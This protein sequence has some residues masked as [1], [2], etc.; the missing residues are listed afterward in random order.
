M[1]NSRPASFAS[2]FSGTTPMAKITRSEATVS[3]VA[4][5][6]SPLFL[7]EVLISFAVSENP[8]TSAPSFKVMP[9][10]RMRLCKSDAMSGS[11]ECI[12]WLGRWSKVTFTPR[13]TRF[14][15]ISRPMN[16]PPTTVARKGFDWA[17]AWL[18]RSACTFSRYSAIPKVSSTVRRV[19][20]REELMPGRFG[21]TGWAPGDKISLS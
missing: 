16:P 14:S 20:I 4:P 2:L 15:A 19:K 21:I 3:P 18:A 17:S 1:P 9:A 6:S 7:K 8:V 10:S 12:R 13:S 5:V 11:S